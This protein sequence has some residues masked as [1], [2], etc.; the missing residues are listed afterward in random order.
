MS[1]THFQ[2]VAQQV[3]C[4]PNVAF[5]QQTHHW[6]KAG[7]FEAMVHDLRA[8][9]SATILDSRSQQSSPE[10]EEWAG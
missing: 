6:L 4:V 3:W 8:P 7:V 9:P 10:S 2:A 1:L 5:I